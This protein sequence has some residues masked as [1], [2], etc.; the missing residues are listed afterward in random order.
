MWIKFHEVSSL[1]RFSEKWELFASELGCGTLSPLI[2]Q[3]I[4]NVLFKRIFES[5]LTPAF[6]LSSSVE[7]VGLT[8]EVDN[9]IH[10][11]GGGGACDQTAEV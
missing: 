6:S 4:T 9:V 1:L 8:Y 11:L 7:D 10:Y 2:Y 5:K 3:H